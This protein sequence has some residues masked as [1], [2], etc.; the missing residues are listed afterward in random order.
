MSVISLSL[1]PTH[2]FSKTLTTTLTLLPDLG[3][4]GDCHC[5]ETVQHRSRLHIRPPPKN[6]RQVHL[7]DAEVLDEYGV[8]PGE[9]GENVTTRGLGLLGLGRGWRL[10]FL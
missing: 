3:V 9:L 4:E 7:I 6:L 1:S 2:D 8:K 10:H 5:G